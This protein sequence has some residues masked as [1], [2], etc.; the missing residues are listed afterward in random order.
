[1]TDFF[2]VQFLLVAALVS[3][4]IFVNGWTDAPCS[5]AS[6]IGSGAMS[7]R[8]AINMAAVFNFLG[9]LIVFSLNDSVA[10]NIQK[11]VDLGTSHPL[12]A[13]C[14]SMIT[15]VIFAVGAWYFGI[16]TSESHALLCALAGAAA[17]TGDGRANYKFWVF[18][19]LSTLILTSAGFLLGFLFDRILKR[20]MLLKNER[21]L[22]VSQVISAALL[23]F[24]HGAQ[25]GQK[26]ASVLL[27]SI[28]LVGGETR[29]S[30]AAVI[31]SAVLLSLGTAVGGMRIIKK[32]GTEITDIDG[33]GG[34]CC[35]VSSFVCLLVCTLLG[36]PVSTTHTKTSAILG[37]GVSRKNANFRSYGSIAAVWLLTFPVCF[38]ISFVITKIC[39]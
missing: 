14:A 26:F 12:T 32:I 20:F 28:C 3:A 38:I 16:P 37:V 39:I 10:K 30:V 35:D 2:N 22:K 19:V 6:C 18:I 23:S 29:K 34:V 9:T 24:I 33:R 36:V 15:I 21:I 17:A 8:D 4:V 31:Y 11:S 13:L 7:A 25:D 27:L 5:V 1:M